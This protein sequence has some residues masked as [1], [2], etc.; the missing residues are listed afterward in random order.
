MKTVDRGD[1]VDLTGTAFTT[2]RGECSVLVTSWNMLTKSLLP[3]PTEHF[4][5]KDEDERYRKRYLD[6]LLDKNLTERVKRRSIFWNT[7]T[8]ISCLSV[9]S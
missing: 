8:T 2:K 9:A 3:V 4:G 1:F 5:I 6:I 7:A